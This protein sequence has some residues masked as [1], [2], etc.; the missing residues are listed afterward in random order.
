MALHEHNLD[1]KSG[2]ELFKDLKDVAS[3]LVEKQ[4]FWLSSADFLLV[5]S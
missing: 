4:F 5:M 2:R 1:A 3:L